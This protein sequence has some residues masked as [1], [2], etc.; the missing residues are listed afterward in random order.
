MRNILVSTA[1][2]HLARYSSLAS[3]DVR[4]ESED[5]D[6]NDNDNGDG[7]GADEFIGSYDISQR[8]RA[9][10]SSDICPQK[11]KTKKGEAPEIVRANPRLLR[12]YDAKLALRLNIHMDFRRCR[13]NARSVT[14][15]QDTF[16]ENI[17]NHR[18][19]RTDQVI[20]H[21]LMSPLR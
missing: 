21:S 1:I 14:T 11:E 5:D 9:S 20:K 2:S 8:A 6:G 4:S 17:V 12:A 10:H 16:S 18:G 13:N 19:T 3:F 15:P 7:D